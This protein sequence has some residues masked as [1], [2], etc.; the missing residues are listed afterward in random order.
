[1][2]ANIDIPEAALKAFCEQHH[3]R[4]LSLF[5]SVLR[6]DFRPDSDID[7]LV[8]FDENYRI[9]LMGFAALQLELSELLQREVHLST[10]RSV[11]ENA[12]HLHLKHVLDS[13]QIIY[14]K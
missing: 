14:T 11:A 4:K 13:S 10:F 8:E 6:D 5:G 12:N 3:I 9:G 2:I 1:M 7:V